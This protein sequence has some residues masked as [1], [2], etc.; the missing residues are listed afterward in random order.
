MISMRYVMISHAH[1]STICQF[2][3]LVL[4]EVLSAVTVLLYAGNM[5]AADTKWP[6]LFRA[7]RKI[8]K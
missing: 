4:T 3:P 8:G 6:A 7:P 2:E 5:P 1:T